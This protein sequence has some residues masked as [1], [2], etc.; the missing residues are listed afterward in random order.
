MRANDPAT[1]PQINYIYSLVARRDTSTVSGLVDTVMRH[2]N[3]GTLKHCTVQSAINVLKAQPRKEAPA[4]REE[5]AVS[6]IAAAAP[7][8]PA[9]YYAVGED[10][11]LRFY[12]V[13]KPTTGRWKGYVF[14]KVQASDEFH[15]IKSIPERARILTEI[16]KD[17]R[18]AAIRYGKKIGRCSICNRT[19][20]KPNSIDMGIGPICASRQGW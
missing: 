14:I 5:S 8:V 12:Q 9:G 17:A 13:D 15:Q 4:Q 20:T 16:A 11:D 3:A 6:A 19:L 10:D 7:L 18:G 1:E 2:I